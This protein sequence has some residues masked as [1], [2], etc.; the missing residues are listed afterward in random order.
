M[1]CQALTQNNNQKS[2]IKFKNVAGPKASA[3][4][5]IKSAA[6]ILYHNSVITTMPST[7]YISLSL[8]DQSIQSLIFSYGKETRVQ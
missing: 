1:F 2:E 7:L 3:P 6:S 5:K 4:M 8:Q